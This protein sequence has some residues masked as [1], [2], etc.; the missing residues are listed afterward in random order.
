MIVNKQ[1]QKGAKVRPGMEAHF[2]I[3]ADKEERVAPDVPELQKILRSSR[4]LQKFYESLSPSMRAGVARLV[5]V[6]KQPATRLRRA[7][8]T[9]E[10]LME[11]M[12]AERELPPLIRQ[13]L[14]RNPK[15][16]E[17]W[18]RMSPTHRRRR[19]LGILYARDPRA[20]LR[21]LEIAIEEMLKRRDA[22]VAGGLT[23]F[24]D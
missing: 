22:K 18:N 9:A 16:F 20:R 2:R 8:Q 7:E 23:D 14:A 24:L 12:E 21:R 15:A 11:T 1:M 6:A 3:E 5:A 19:L 13:T 10:W 17:L 4:P